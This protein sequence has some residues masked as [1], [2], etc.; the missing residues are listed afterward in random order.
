MVVPRDWKTDL[1]LGKNREGTAS[2]AHAV[3][4]REGGHRLGR[5]WKLPGFEYSSK[6]SPNIVKKFCAYKQKDA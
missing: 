6:S 1:H 2:Q 4:L 5:P 3:T